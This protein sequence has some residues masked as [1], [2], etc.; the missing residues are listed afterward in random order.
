LQPEPIARAVLGP[1]YRAKQDRVVY[2]H[3]DHSRTRVAHVFENGFSDKPNGNGHS[4]RSMRLRW[5]GAERLPMEFVSET[6]G[7]APFWVK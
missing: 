6:T 1:D 5:D 4:L 3:W 2:C 7:R